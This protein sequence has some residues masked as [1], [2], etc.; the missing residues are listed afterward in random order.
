[1][2][3]PE[4]IVPTLDSLLADQAVFMSK[5]QSMEPHS[6]TPDEVQDLGSEMAPNFE[7]VAE[8]IQAIVAVKP[9]P[10]II[11][12]RFKRAFENVGLILELQT[13]LIKKPG[14]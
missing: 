4:E 12:D 10:A 5:L 14:N 7:M 11:G 3:A 8:M 6:M 2:I 1:M 9:D 13:K